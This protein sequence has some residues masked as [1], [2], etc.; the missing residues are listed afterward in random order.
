M[1]Q[2]AMTLYPIISFMIWNALFPSKTLFFSD[3]VIPLIYKMRSYAKRMLK[4]AN[5]SLRLIN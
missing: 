3:T 2:K 1:L 5:K 4:K